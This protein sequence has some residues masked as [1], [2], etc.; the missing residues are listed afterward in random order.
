MRQP[1]IPI[2]D[3]KFLLVKQVYVVLNWPAKAAQIGDPGLQKVQHLL[4][5]RIIEAG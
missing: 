5:F 2:I 1:Q 3:A 4:P